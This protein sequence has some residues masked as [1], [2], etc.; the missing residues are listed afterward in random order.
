MQHSAEIRLA[1]AL[2][3]SRKSPIGVFNSS[4]VLDCSAVLTV[5]LDCYPA[6]PTFLLS[7]SVQYLTV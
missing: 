6:V 7:T 3:E 2:L 4:A 1:F 5:A